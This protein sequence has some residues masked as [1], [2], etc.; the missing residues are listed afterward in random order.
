[1]KNDGKDVL[2]TIEIP[3]AS[4]E[5]LE[6]DHAASGEKEEEDRAAAGGEI[7]PEAGAS[8]EKK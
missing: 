1:M 3:A 6:E 8:E 5:K 4:G 2:A 7:K